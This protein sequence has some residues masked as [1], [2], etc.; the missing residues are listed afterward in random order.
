MQKHE[1]SMKVIY[2]LQDRELQRNFQN[3]LLLSCLKLEDKFLFRNVYFPFIP[4]HVLLV[5]VK[6]LPLKR[7]SK[8]GDSQHKKVY[9]NK[10]K[11]TLIEAYL[12]S[13]VE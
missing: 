6:H 3:A 12:L 1:S 11:F 9:Q 13:N 10:L 4:F 5:T 8:K 2:I 7:L